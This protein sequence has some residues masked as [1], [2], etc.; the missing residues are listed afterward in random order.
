MPSLV[1]T[2]AL[3]PVVREPTLRSEQVTQLLLGRTAEI[4][5][6][7]APWHRIRITADA[8]EGWVHD[9]YVRRLDDAEARAW[10]LAADGWSEGAA[11][12]EG[13]RIVR[14]PVGGRVRLARH[15]VELP[16]GRV[17][18]ILSGRIAP[19]ATIGVEAR[20]IPADK[21]LIR[22]F[23]GAP[24]EWGGLSPWGVDCSGLIQVG[25]AARGIALPRDSFLQ[26][27]VGDD[28]PREE[29]QRG[30]L[31][32]FSENGRT[33]THVALL[34]ADHRLVHSSLSCGGFV[35]EPW[36]PGTRAAPLKDLLVGVRRLAAAEGPA[37]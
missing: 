20:A 21:W 4:L 1:V 37:L 26:A 8:Y 5:E 3:A 18:R 27:E 13:E 33:V 19:A 28:V 25:F 31:L 29:A 32:F 22:F 9:G 11:V 34:G 35:V 14:V 15:G 16:D 24:Y 23:A 10:T 12:E 2:A 36:G 17:G 7:R 6:D 30:D